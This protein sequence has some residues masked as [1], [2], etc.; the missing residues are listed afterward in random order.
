MKRWIATA[1][2]AVLAACANSPPVD[3]PSAPGSFR[4]AA[5]EQSEARALERAEADCVTQGKHAVA[6][7]VDGETLY[8]CVAR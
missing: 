5:E 6:K 2:A 4:P 8:E 3:N 1:C 7:R